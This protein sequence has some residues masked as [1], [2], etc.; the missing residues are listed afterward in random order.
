ML[1]LF[2]R[3]LATQRKRM[4]GSKPLF[5]PYAPA[6]DIVNVEERLGVSL[7]DSL[8]GWLLAAGYGVSALG[9]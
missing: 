5:E 8:K 4:F 2:A 6:I 9:S 3:I 1:N 7:P